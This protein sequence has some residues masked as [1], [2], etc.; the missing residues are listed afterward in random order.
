MCLNI[1]HKKGLQDKK[2]GLQML[3]YYYRLNTTHKILF[4]SLPEN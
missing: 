4:I 1:T 3:I 2:A